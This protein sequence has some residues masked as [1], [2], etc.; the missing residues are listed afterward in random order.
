[1]KLL[2]HTYHNLRSLSNWIDSHR[3]K[4]YPSILIQIFFSNQKDEKLYQVRSE[5]LSL[6]PDCSL[7]ATSTAGT[8]SDGEM[9]DDTILISCSVFEASK[10]SCVGYTNT[11]IDTLIEKLSVNLIN[12]T[13]KLLV[14][15]AN[16]FRFNSAQLLQKLTNLYPHIVIVGGNAGDDYYFQRCVVFSKE[17][18]D[19]DIVFAAIN[20][21]QLRISTKYLLNCQSIGQ[22]MLVTKSQGGEVFEIDHK[23]P[24]DI[25]THYLG[26]DIADNILEYGI[27]FPLI[28][29]IGGVE[30]ARSPVAVNK[31]LGFMSFAGDIPEG[32][33]VRFGHLNIEHIENQNKEILSHQFPHKNKAIYIY[34]CAARRQILGD[35]LNEELSYI[36]QI[37]PTSGFITYGEFFHNREGCH[38]NLLNITTTFVTLNETIPNEKVNFV[39]HARSKEKS[40]VTLKALTTLI[41]KTSDELEEF[42]QLLKHELDTTNKSLE[43]NLHYMTQYEDAINS[44]TAILKTDTHNIIQ[45]ANDKFCNLSGYTLEELVGMDCKAMSH[46]KHKSDNACSKVRKVM[47]NIAKNGQEYIVNTLFYPIINIQGEL[48]E[49]LQ[50]MHDITEIISLNEEIVNTQREVVFT[51][52]AIGE[53]RS[54][55]TGLHVKRVA[56]YSY[57]LAKLIGL[58]EEEASLLKQASPMH[59]IGK[60][61]IPD[62]ILNKP[63]KLTFEEFEIMK[64]HAQL[65]FEMLNH[66]DRPILKT[67]ALVASTH[68][69]KWDGSGYP[70][71]TKGGDIHIFGR[72]TAIA[73]VFDALGH[74]RIYKKAWP[75]EE[76]LELFQKERGKHFDPELIDIFFNHLDQFLEI[77][78]SLLD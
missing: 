39:S 14:I 36:N 74:D 31:E 30:I 9:I 43:E 50:I 46:E 15:F 53:T 1:M 59:D 70:N 66:S 23:S 76:I 28:F 61:A 71:Q 32:I 21:H 41:S 38:N 55:E 3:L 6:L 69:E 62:S 51:M 13:T 64:T 26:K 16:T 75:L 49:H 24:L 12:D 18:E 48:V 37:G 7:I 27:E 44:T 52:G 11:S 22:E 42:K 19:C 65:G 73:D 35:F 78:D 4:T 45:Y 8:I 17:E 25:Y 34:S 10:V 60:V 47:T 67:S 72:I 63:G 5:I 20:S 2:N 77:R 40:K 54:K 58:S 29:N 57:L 68:H 56:E 33:F